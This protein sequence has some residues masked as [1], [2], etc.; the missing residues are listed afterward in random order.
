MQATS[1]S[2]TEGQEDAAFEAA[3]TPEDAANK[4]ANIPWRLSKEFIEDVFMEGG[5]KVRA[6]GSVGNTKV[7]GKK[8]WGASEGLATDGEAAEFCDSIADWW[9]DVSLFL[10]VK[11]CLNRETHRHSNFVNTGLDQARGVPR[12][13]AVPEGPGW[14]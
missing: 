13:A 3:N 6:K 14:V 1:S 10:H 9:P 7:N 12:D 4:G 8:G 11:Y 2:A 5:A